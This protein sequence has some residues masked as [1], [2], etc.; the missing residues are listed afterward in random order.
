MCSSMLNFTNKHT[1]ETEKERFPVEVPL[2]VM[3]RRR[4]IEAMTSE[5]SSRDVRFEVNEEE[6]AG[7]GSAFEF[8]IQLPTPIA[9]PNGCLL[10]CHCSLL[11]RM[12]KT[13][14]RTSMHA[15]IDR[16]DILRASDLGPTAGQL[17][18]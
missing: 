13:G 2:F 12:E 9:R 14:K 6:G 1:L 16:Y 18:A 8:L 3:T 17:D 10:R 5:M 15:R 7:I 11:S 4:V